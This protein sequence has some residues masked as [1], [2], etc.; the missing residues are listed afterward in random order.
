MA[1]RSKQ[2]AA[3]RAGL[4]NNN[5]VIYTCPSGVTALVKDINIYNRSGAIQDLRVGVDPVGAV[6]ANITYEDQAFPIKGTWHFMPWWVLLPGDSLF[7]R[8]DGAAATDG[9]FC[10]VSGSELQGIAP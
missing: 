7:V 1:V 4:A 6:T 9:L 3:R 5:V 2:L 10:L 8:I